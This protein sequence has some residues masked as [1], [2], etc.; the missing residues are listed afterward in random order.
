MAAEPF[1][2]FVEPA[3][4]SGFFYN[5]LRLIPPGSL[6]VTPFI[7]LADTLRKYSKNHDSH[8]LLS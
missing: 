3:I 6:P 5:I 1:V 7:L 8:S 4:F 2:P